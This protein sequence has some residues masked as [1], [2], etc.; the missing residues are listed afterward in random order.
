MVFAQAPCSPGRRKWR[1]GVCLGLL[2]AP[3][4]GISDITE[5]YLETFGEP[6]PGRK[7]F[8][9]ARQQRDGWEDRAKDVS[10]LVPVTRLAAQSRTIVPPFLFPISKPCRNPVPVWHGHHLPTQPPALCL[11]SHRPM[12]RPCTRDRYHAS[13]GAPPVQCRSGSGH[14]SPLRPAALLSRLRTLPG[15]RRIG[16]WRELWHGG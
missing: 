15:P 1:H 2:P 8:I 3:Q 16:H 9:R 11:P 6:E 5:M 10:G 7:V 12:H 13:T 4:N 14:P